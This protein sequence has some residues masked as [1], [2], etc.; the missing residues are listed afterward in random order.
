MRALHLW[1]SFAV[2]IALSLTLLI[3]G[4]AMLDV[5]IQHGDLQPPHLDISFVGLHIV[6][7][8]IDPME[9]WPYTLCHG[10]SRAY[11]EVW[12]SYQAAPEHVPEKGLR[13]LA[14]PLQEH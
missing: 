6:A 5:A 1:K 8:T 3:G 7:R 14:I 2:A 10:S 9:C 13:I 12:V 4:A 11:Y